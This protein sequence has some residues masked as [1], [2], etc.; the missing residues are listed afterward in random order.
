HLRRLR[1]Q[2]PTGAPLVGLQ[3]V[4][5]VLFL[6]PLAVERRELEG[7]RRGRVEQGGDEPD[8]AFVACA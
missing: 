3:L 7:R 2:D 1:A 8:R 5:G 6:P 4:E